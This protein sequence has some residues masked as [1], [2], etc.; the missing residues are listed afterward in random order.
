M[1]PTPHRTT[2]PH[3]SAPPEASAALLALKR[4]A[5][6]SLDRFLHVEAAGGVVLLLAAVVALVW[7]NS[8]W[9]ASYFRLWHTP[10]GIRLG[11]F[12]FERPI[13]ADFVFL[14]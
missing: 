6:R 11:A 2:A 1:A 12:A 10:I 9:A 14:S 5:G 7:A 3:R 4:R 8:P 13:G